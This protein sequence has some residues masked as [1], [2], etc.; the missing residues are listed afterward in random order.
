MKKTVFTI[1][2]VFVIFFASCTK[3]ELTEPQPRI[4]SFTATVAEPADTRA[5]LEDNA[6]TIRFKWE[7]T[8][9][10]QLAFVQGEEKKTADATITSVSTDGRTAQFSVTVPS[11]ITGDFTLYAYYCKLKNNGGGILLA[12]DPTIAI[13]PEKPWSRLAFLG[14]EHS[15]QRYII[16]LWTK[17]AVIYSGGEMPPVSLSFSH[18]GAMMTVKVTNNTGAEV[19]NIHH[20]SIYGTQNWTFNNSGTGKAHFDM[21][22]G[23]Y[24]AGEERANLSL[25]IYTNMSGYPVMRIPA[26]E[27]KTY[28][29]WFVPGAYNVSH[30]LKMRAKNQS[31]DIT[32]DSNNTK[33]Q[34]NFQP[35]HNYIVSVNIVSGTGTTGDPYV[36]HFQE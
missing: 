5:I 22:T 10:I 6:G 30:D 8:D 29:T 35:G 28:Y 23:S 13:L 32:G 21:T 1:A 34:Y 14:D 27:T 19:N 3:N 25:R 18:L 11:E 9:V 26:G 31:F 36:L 15:G 20:F 2:A 4:M 17:Q 24:V 33:T 7:L 12:S 16:S